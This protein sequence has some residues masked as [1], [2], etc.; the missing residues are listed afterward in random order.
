[1]KLT[2]PPLAAS[3]ARASSRLSRMYSLKLCSYQN[4]ADRRRQGTCRQ[5][6]CISCQASA[7]PL[8][9]PSHNGMAAA[10]A[11][12]RTPTSAFRKESMPSIRSTTTLLMYSA[13]GFCRLSLQQCSHQTGGERQEPT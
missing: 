1:M 6:Q 5:Q 10:H 3:L 7:K 8:R 11:L 13:S 9:R 4:S 12:R 2:W